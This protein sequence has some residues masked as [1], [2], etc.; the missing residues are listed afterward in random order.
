[1]AFRFLA[2]A[3]AAALGLAEAQEG[4]KQLS[5]DALKQAFVNE[6]SFHYYAV[7]IPE[8]AK[9][10]KV[11]LV[12]TYGDPD[13]YLSFNI[14]EPDDLT[15][16]WV[17]DDVGAEEL[18]IRRDAVDFCQ[19]EPCILHMSVYGY[20]E[21]D[22][23]IGVF[24]AESGGEI[25]KQVEECSKGCKQDFIADGVCQEECKNDACYQDG[26][27][28]DKKKCAPG[29]DEGWVGDDYCDEACFVEECKWD[30]GD[31]SEKTGCSTGCLP[32]YIN[33]G[34]C[35][36]ECNVPECDF[37]GDDCFHGAS[38]CYGEMDGSD[39]R[40]TINKT[41][42]GKTC[43]AWDAQFP[44]QHT[45]THLNYPEAGLGGHNNCRNP[46]GETGPYCYTT[47][48]DVRFELCNVGQPWQKCKQ[49]EIPRAQQLVG[50]VQCL[51]AT[52]PPSGPLARFESS[53]GDGQSH[54]DVCSR[55]CCNA[56]KAASAYCNNDEEYHGRF[57]DYKVKVAFSQLKNNCTQCEAFSD[58]FS[59]AHILEGVGL[60]SSG[61]IKFVDTVG[62]KVLVAAFIIM[63][64]L[65][66]VIAASIARYVYQRRQYAVPDAAV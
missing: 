2:V 50:G 33:D 64:L 48:P 35:D 40:G 23:M 60:G 3:L 30:G 5:M 59:N 24:K 43:Q 10:I 21:S 16:T 9:A 54:G 63:L 36:S 26:G 47:D 15:A 45:R 37:D 38:E 39:Y 28:C 22:Y 25:N 56:A 4:E 27:D 42:S 53:C 41:K 32:D 52:T 62:F 51:I 46:D 6:D 29:C 8:S 18:V 66:C 34:E 13:V 58:F 57:T 44:H 55:T 14:Q 31:C 19:S 20:D 49:N 11:K 17:M 65:L 12:P 61:M 7:S 1:M